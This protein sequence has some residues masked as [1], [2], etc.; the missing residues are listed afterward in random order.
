MRD[1][2]AFNVHGT[3]IHDFTCFEIVKKLGLQEAFD[4]MSKSTW[5]TGEKPTSFETKQPDVWGETAYFILNKGWAIT[6]VNR[7]KG[8]IEAVYCHDGRYSLHRAG[9]QS[10]LDRIRGSISW[11]SMFRRIYEQLTEPHEHA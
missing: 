6:E 8:Y 10:F 1:N 2:R 3:Y 11:S 5:I 4:L 9:I 7:E